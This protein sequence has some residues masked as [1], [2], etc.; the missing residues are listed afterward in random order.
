MTR[1]YRRKVRFLPSSTRCISKAFLADEEPQWA[2]L[3]PSGLAVAGG[4]TET[5]LFICDG[6]V[7]G[8]F[9]RHLI[10]DY[11]REMS[12]TSKITDYDERWPLQFEA[13]A[14]RLRPIFSSRL[15]AIHHIGSTAVKGLAAKPEVDVLVAVTGRKLLDAWLDSLNELGYRRGSDLVE[16]HYFFKRDVHG[17]RTH[18]LHVCE[19]EHPQVRR[20]L[21]IRDHLCANAEDRAAY[22]ALKLRLEKENQTGIAEYLEG[23]S[24]F[25]DEMY[26]RCCSH[27]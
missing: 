1:I 24:P 27:Q 9:K 17:V 15:V 14:K 7:N 4:R 16:G 2:P 18:K 25:L 21:K 26:R 8:H 20:M 12:L 5:I 23:K 6:A 10:R 13:E 3:H 22:A 11:S 19:Q